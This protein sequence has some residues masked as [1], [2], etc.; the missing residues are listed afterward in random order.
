[1]KRTEDIPMALITTVSRGSYSL[2]LESSEF[3]VF[4]SGNGSQ[5]LSGYVRPDYSGLAI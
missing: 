3:T 2:F 1:M 5:E 4:I